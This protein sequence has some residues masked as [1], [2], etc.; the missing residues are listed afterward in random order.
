M[1]R[2]KQ[3]QTKSDPG[4]RNAERATE[5][6]E[7]LANKRVEFLGIQICHHISPACS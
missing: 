2:V 1:E 4:G 6:A 7:H 5:I 3:S